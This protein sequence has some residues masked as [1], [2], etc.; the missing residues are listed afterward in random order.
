MAVGAGFCFALASL[1][2][3]GIFVLPVA[4]LGLAL[5]LSR[6]ASRHGSAAG[7]ICGLGL[8]PL[9]IAYLNWGGPGDVCTST[10]AREACSQE[11]S[12]WPFLVSG[13]FLVAAGLAL[14]WWL[15]WRAAHRHAS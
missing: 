12:P 3:I 15:R 6:P 1:P 13:L 7:A 14:F 2:S 4:V 5:L 9:C 11:W 10:S 8:I